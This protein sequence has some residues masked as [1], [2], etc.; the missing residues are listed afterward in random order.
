M[1]QVKRD[2]KFRPKA[3]LRAGVMPLSAKGA[4]KWRAAKIRSGRAK[5][6]DRR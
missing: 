2:W 5:Q 1:T 4:V 3:R 6:E